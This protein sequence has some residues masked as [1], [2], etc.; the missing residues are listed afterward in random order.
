MCSQPLA[1]LALLSAALAADSPAAE[2]AAGKRTM[3]TDRYGDPLPEGA[4]MRLGTARF[5]PASPRCLVFSPDGKHLISAGGGKRIR[6]WDANTGKELRVLDGHKGGVHLISLSAD[7]KCLA[8]CDSDGE[9]LIWEFDTGKVWKRT[10]RPNMVSHGFSLSSNGKILAT[11]GGSMLRLWDTDT[12]KETLT[13]ASPGRRWPETLAFTPDS[14]QLAYSDSANQDI[15]LLDVAT[16][17]EI[18]TFKSHKSRICQLHF[19]PDGAT[20]FSC[21]HDCTIRSWDVASGKERRRYGD[22]K[23]TVGCFAL[24]PDGRTLTYSTGALVHIWDME[25]NKDRMP[26]CESKAWITP[27]IAYSP[28]SKKVAVGGESI[29]L[30]ETATGKRLNPALESECPVRQVKYALGGKSFLVRRWHDKTIELWDTTK[31]LKTRMLHPKIGSFAEMIVSPDGKHLATAEGDSTQGKRRCL[32]CTWDL[33]TGERQKEIPL[34]NS[35]FDSFSYSVDGKTLRYQQVDS[36][37]RVF[38]FRDSATGEETARLPVSERQPPGRYV[39]PQCKPVLTSDGRVLVWGF[40]DFTVMGLWDT[41]TGTLF[42]SFGDCSVGVYFPPIFSPDGRTVAAAG[43]FG[44]NGRVPP[45]PDIVL[46]EAATGKERLRIVP[47]DWQTKHLVFSPNGRLLASAGQWETIRVWDLWTGKEVGRFSGHRGPINTL[48]FA[49]DSKTLASGGAD[50]NVLVWDV[51]ALAPPMKPATEKLS[52]AELVQCWDNLAGD[53]PV[54]AYATLFRLL[55]HPKQAESLLEDKLTDVKKVDTKHVAR[56]IADL[57]SDDF[58]TRENASKSL[59]NLGRSTESALRKSQ[60]GKLS[61]E[62]KRRI[63]ELVDKLVRTEDDPVQRRLHRAIETLERLGTAKARRLLRKLVETAPD[64]DT[65]REAQ[66]S[67]ERLDQAE[68]GNP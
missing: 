10:W 59:A 52:R 21:S 27:A 9:V 44:K 15:H 60:E 12:L 36:Q 18:R 8:S 49:P 45:L 30:Y 19:A 16:G 3:R 41:K 46:W 24:A 17:E 14:K 28:D 5:S 23:E 11:S 47:N 34:D 51:S 33:Q 38:I 53:D 55:Q 43:S 67:L 63:Q 22:E 35:W 26:P 68:T 6:I 61:A 56:L 66:A 4:I 13:L 40:V 20:L 48:S 29:A 25:K 31:W 7:G 37:R 1:L 62:S 50:S 32:I 54:Q 65:A 64:A 42:R 57:D 39:H 58:T 2:Q